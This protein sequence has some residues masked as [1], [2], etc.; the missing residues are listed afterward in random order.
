MHAQWHNIHTH[1]PPLA[2]Q[3]T[4]NHTRGD[5]CTY[6][7]SGCLWYGFRIRCLFYS[8]GIWSR[9]L[10]VHSSS[11]H[12][13]LSSDPWPTCRRVLVVQ[14][15]VRNCCISKCSGWD[16]DNR[17][18]PGRS[19]KSNNNDN[20]S[21]IHPQSVNLSL[22]ALWAIMRI[23]ISNNN[24]DYDNNDG[25]D[26]DDNNNNNNNN[27]CYR[28]APRYRRM[29]STLIGYT[30]WQWLPTFATLPPY[31]TLALFFFLLRSAFSWLAAP[32]LSSSS[33]PTMTSTI[34]RRR[35]C[36]M[37]LYTHRQRSTLLASITFLERWHN[38]SYLLSFWCG[39]TGNRDNSPK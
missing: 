36:I 34:A 7:C 21:N 12:L 13:L 31:R 19:N 16:T 1:V 4:P 14:T 2:T 22:V 27:R 5:L 11:P 6:I 39:C 28:T 38:T 29:H 8:Q 35:L 9:L 24:N 37:T 3:G 30:M 10:A 20:K 26:D 33:D 15:V 32:Q 23:Q 25:E 17:C 18:I